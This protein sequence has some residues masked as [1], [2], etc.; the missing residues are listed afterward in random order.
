MDGLVFVYI[1]AATAEQARTIGRR[2]VEERLAACANIVPGM[3]SVYRWQGR[4]ETAQEAVLI[5]KTRAVLVDQVAARVR[6]L[7]SY[8]CPCV[9]SMPITGGNPAFLRWLG[10]ETAAV[11]GTAIA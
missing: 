5:A 8:D 7:H 3:E 10:E 2:L 9:V 11:G 1:T 4:V 6:E